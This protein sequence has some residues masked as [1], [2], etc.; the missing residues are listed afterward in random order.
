MIA[1]IDR[2][3]GVNRTGKA[4]KREAVRAIILRGGEILL[5][6]AKA[7]GDYKFP[8]GG[9]FQGARHEEA[10]SRELM[11]ECGAELLQIHRP[12][13]K[14]V[15]YAFPREPDFEVYRMASYYYFCAIGAELGQQ[16]LERYELDLGLERNWTAIH[17]E[18]A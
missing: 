17:G 3:K 1:E 6:Y 8:G 2:H 9:V 5:L 10:L 12:F 18:I 7:T 14:V 13:G 16:H 15:E 4:V 11:E